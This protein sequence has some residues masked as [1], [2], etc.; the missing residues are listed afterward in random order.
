MYLVE[1]SGVNKRKAEVGMISTII[2]AGIN[3]ITRC[4]LT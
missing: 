3:R 1:Q 4:W 2:P